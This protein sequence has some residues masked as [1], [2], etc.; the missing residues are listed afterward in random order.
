MLFIRLLG[1]FDVRLNDQPVEIKSRSAQTLISYLALTAGMSHR[2]EKLAGLFWPDS[3]EANA[4]TYL[5]QSL[6]RLRKSFEPFSKSWEDYFQIDDLTITFLE[7]SNY[8]LDSAEIL[9]HKKTDEW[10][11]GD[12]IKIIGYYQGELLPGFYD[13]WV[14]L[15]RERVHAAYDNKARILFNLLLEAKRWEDVIEWG[16]N[17]NRFGFVP[18]TIYRALMIA[19]ACLG[20]QANIGLTFQRCQDALDR[21][22]GIHPSSE[23]EI[24]YQQLIRG[25]IPDEITIGSPAKPETIADAPPH[26]G[27]SPYKGLEFFDTEDAEI[28][29]GRQKLIA[30]L[31]KRLEEDPSLLIIVGASGSGKSSVVRAGLIPAI[32]EKSAATTDL[33]IQPGSP[34]WLVKVIT[35]TAH[36]LHSLAISLT[37]DLSTP[38]IE[39]TS[40]IDDLEADARTLKLFTQKTIC[41]Q[42]DPAHFLLVVD[43][44]EEIFTLCRSEK[45]R[46]AF[47]N[48][49]LYL[50]KEGSPCTIILT[51]R[52]DF[53]SQC[54]EYP[55]LRKSLAQHQEYIGAMNAQE[56]R[57]VIEEPA[58]LNNW[59]IEPRLVGMILRDISREPGSLPLLSHSLLE[60]WQ[61]RSGRTM[62]LKGYADSGGVH[63]AI[64]RTAENVYTHQLTDRQKT[65]GR[66]VFT[67]LT[68]LGEG[69][70]DTRRRIK[71]DELYSSKFDKNDIRQVLDILANARLI[72]LGKNTV[73][74]AHE[75]LIREWPT[76]GKWLKED[77]QGLL[78]H[79]HLT[80]ASQSWEALEYDEGELYRSARLTQASEWAAENPDNLNDLEQTFLEA[81]QIFAQQKQDDQIQLN[82]RLRWQVVG[83]TV[84]LIFALIST[85]FGFYLRNLA[86]QEA[87]LARSRELA[88]AAV[89][90]LEVDPDLSIILALEAIEQTE[91]ISLPVTKEAKE[92]LHQSILASRVQTVLRGHTDSVLGIDIDSAGKMIATTSQDGVV[93][94]WDFKS[95]QEI[96]TLEG[97][98]GPVT[99]VV[100]DP[101]G[102]HLATSGNDQSVIIW[103]LASGKAILSLEGHEHW[104]N[105]IAYSPDGK[106]IATAS[107]DKT[108]KLWDPT[109]GELL[110]TFSGHIAAIHKVRIS[111]DN[112]KILTASFDSTAILWDLHSTVPLFILPHQDFVID[113]TFSPDGTLAATASVDDTAKLWDT[114]TGQEI[115]T[116]TGHSE[117]LTGIKFSPDGT[118]IA[119]S[120]WDRTVILWDVENG[121]QELVLR[122][123]QDKLN[124]LV[125]SPDSKHLVTSSDDATA[126]IWNIS[127][128]E[129]Y[130]SIPAPAGVLDLDFNKDGKLLGAAL[131]G[132][133]G[134]KI[135]DMTT[136]Q[137]I[138]SIPSDED[139]LNNTVIKF[140]P[141]Q[142]IAASLMEKSVQIWNYTDGKPLFELI[143]HDAE[144]NDIAYSP[145][146]TRIATA[147]DDFHSKVWET[148]SGQELA[149]WSSL[150]GNVKS[151]A[152]SANGQMI[153]SGDFK[154]KVRVWDAAAGKDVFTISDHLDQINQISFSSD[155]IHLA[156]ASSDAT[157]SLWHAESGE[158]I[159]T[160]HGHSGA[161]T[162]AVFNPD[163]T[164]L[165]TSSRDGKAILWDPSTG[166]SVLTLS[167][168]TTAGQTG[169]SFSPDGKLLAVGSDDGLRLYHVDLQDLIALAKTQRNRELTTD[170]CQ[171]Y[172][173]PHLCPK[174]LVT[175]INQT[176]RLPNTEGIHKICLIG[177]AGGAEF[178]PS[179][180]FEYQ[181]Y[182]GAQEAAMKFNWIGEIY[183]PR[184]VTEEN[185]GLLNFLNKDCT[186]ITGA[187]LVGLNSVQDLANI[188]PEQKFLLMDFFSE[189]QPENIWIERFASD[190]AAF[191]AGYAAASVTKTGKVGTFG[192]VY[193]PPVLDFMIAFE[194]G[195][196]YYNQRHNAEVQLTGW[197]TKA[198]DGIFIG[199][200]WSE[201]DGYQT[202]K[203]LIENQDV[204]IIF[205]VAGG[206]V[207][208]G[209]LKSAAEHE[210]VFVI[211]VDTDWHLTFPEYQDIILTS[212]LK[213][214][215]ISVVRVVEAIENGTFSGGLHTANL[216]NGGV[217]LSPFYQNQYLISDD[218][219]F[220]LEQIREQIIAG[221]ITTRP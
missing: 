188:Y 185:Q 11:I 20:D 116:F 149:S 121:H 206:I 59:E 52:A 190:E 127:L 12:L 153:A 110:R 61:R 36:P 169:L 62:T 58:K 21:D 187:P 133:D 181:F 189:T 159:F 30:Q 97:H 81:S 128:E 89:N 219:L 33:N 76:L 106:F 134:V 207:G 131:G 150:G 9:K 22:F 160:L 171:E 107:S 172:Q 82:R 213:R 77:R 71:I 31:L 45:E 37:Q 211:G 177:T 18:E 195:V 157:A 56:L 122:G 217:G 145:D 192:G 126:R 155:G 67:R 175:S 103:D 176:P 141:H 199:N 221:K 218:I 80:E 94:L 3:N 186:L 27:S 209:V 70:V 158:K 167:N 210:N 7:E 63:R 57:Q 4:R 163:N 41:S 198:N 23:L 72:V 26:A 164:L 104:V 46:A 166:Q 212:V 39:T 91:S 100:F 112:S 16:E 38:I 216:D 19:H 144:V 1:Q 168:E 170:E 137:E 88:A 10:A 152:F 34:D 124:D 96:Q 120:S 60:T 184:T 102:E 202:T 191:L 85:G 154:G 29:F 178:N 197:S 108:A 194:Q 161:V 129:E 105:G 119:T 40:L 205:P 87:H 136:R 99:D 5:R 220:E 14:I 101:Q 53:Y 156:I 79:R 84:F 86:N 208:I 74:V 32:L 146:G 73:E 151:I 47:I 25:Q 147:S 8:L 13:D 180:W 162:G 173:L 118:K 64:A 78:I 43:Q 201:D 135:W 50:S 17:R 203:E 132:N 115:F 113:G 95:G 51:L 49:L 140:G 55:E 48:N 28:F 123:H 66:F 196:F 92:A 179:S 44:F 35:P 139:H 174:I 90:N 143:G 42:Q 69:I 117:D 2:R 15:D 68:E 215:D 125:F 98:V 142:T 65:I 93:I 193:I 204:D 200:F 165:A 6:W 83:L 75:A 183:Q 148:S 130:L 109:T 138:F 111:P 24:L 182:K 114:L 214:M 54:A